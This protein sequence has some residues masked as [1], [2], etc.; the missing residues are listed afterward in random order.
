MEKQSS[1][2]AEVLFP[3]ALVVATGNIATKLCPLP[4]LEHLG[5]FSTKGSRNEKM[6]EK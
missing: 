6:S 2:R 5:S 4:Y 1:L 3:E